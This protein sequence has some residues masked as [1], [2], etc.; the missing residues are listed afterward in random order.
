MIDAGR[1]T[2]DNAR[3]VRELRQGETIGQRVRRLRLEQGLSQRE[4]SRPGVSYAYLSR[5]EA[6]YRTPSLK[7]LRLLA[8]RLGVTAE[9]L[10]TGEPIPRATLREL[11]IVDAEI[12]LRLGRDLGKAET[13][14]REQAAD[15]QNE[16]ALIAR[17]QAGLGFLAA[18]RGETSV[19]IELLE[20]AAISIKNRGK[21]VEL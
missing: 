15:E 19:A 16:P 7:A 5:I 11:R 3:P 14:F 18:R 20:A 12:E 2:N 4:L 21:L 10:E 13:V 9:Y 8:E 1:L 17:A 6:G